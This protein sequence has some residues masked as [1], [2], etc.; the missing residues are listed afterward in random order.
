MQED[1][2]KKE[3]L[4]ADDLGML[5]PALE[6]AG[7]TDEELWGDLEKAE[8]G[9]PAHEPD[10]AAD[11]ETP[12]DDGEDDGTPEDEPAD[13]GTDTGTPDI[14]AGA[15]P[16]QRHAFEE[17]QKRASEAEH[18]L[19]S[20]DGRVS[21]LQKKINRLTED[22][23]S[24]KPDANGRQRNETATEALGR[25][26]TDYPEIAELLD[27][28]LASVRGDVTALSDAETKRIQTAQRDLDESR[29]ELASIANNNA[30]TVEQ[31][32]PGYER[33]L[34]ENQQA[35]VAWV[36]DQPR[37]I[38]EA[39]YAN[40]QFVADPSAAIDVINRFKAHINPPAQMPDTDRKN[41]D[42]QNNPLNDRRRRQLDASASPQRSARRPA[43]SGVPED[44]DP[45]AIW[46]AFEAHEQAKRA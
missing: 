41:A 38:R 43:V 25:L 36:E 34:V 37:A 27:P 42:P 45:Q 10:A 39:A 12:P 35:F 11:F 18:R 44:G 23:Q 31:A 5:D 13:A 7:K 21:S 24:R 29:T 8:N 33:F 46:D 16:E 19:R 26:K 1:T 22:L 9:K 30:R 28:V 17:A 32:H 15:S 20:D 14:W 6:D 40:A 4:T 3:D 2:Q